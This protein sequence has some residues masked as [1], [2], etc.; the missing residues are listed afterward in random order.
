MKILTTTSDINLNISG[1]QDFKTNLGWHENFQ[2]FEDKALRTIINPVDNYETTR[3]IHEPYTGITS[4]IS[5]CDI[6]FY[7]Y[8][9]D[10]VG[11]YIKGLDYN[12]VGLSPKENALMLKQTVKSFFRL[13]F[14]TTP[15]RENQKL[16]YAKTLSLPLGQKVFLSD[17]NDFIRVPVFTGNNYSNTENMYFFWF[18]DSSVYS[19]TTFYMSARFFN[20]EDGSVIPFVNKDVSATSFI[21]KN[22]LY[23]QITIDQ[24]NHSYIVKQYNGSVGSR[25]GFKNTP[26]N[27]YE[28]RT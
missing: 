1:E 23:Y 12:L 13:E 25:K 16:I 8:F 28:I 20:A 5:Q 2:E 6:W 3:Y 18:Q 27:F 22:D 15:F 24:T 7:F 9:L 21:D 14:F 4:G 10:E 26:I 11:S 17:L 19:G